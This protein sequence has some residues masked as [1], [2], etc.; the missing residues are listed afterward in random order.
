MHGDIYHTTF[1]TIDEVKEPGHSLRCSVWPSLS[2]IS[3][4]L[5]N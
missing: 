2:F 5:V 3:M 4:E 1:T